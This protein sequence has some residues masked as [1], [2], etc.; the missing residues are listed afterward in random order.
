[1]NHNEIKK[2]YS[3]F[4]TSRKLYSSALNILENAIWFIVLFYKYTFGL[5]I[6][7]RMSKPFFENLN[8]QNVW[9]TKVGEHLN[10]IAWIDH[11]LCEF[12]NRNLTVSDIINDD[13]TQGI[14]SYLCNSKISSYVKN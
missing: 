14:N 13:K 2:V 9:N 11:L 6:H 5:F 7:S 4:K 1:M 8:L 10:V 3:S 12:S